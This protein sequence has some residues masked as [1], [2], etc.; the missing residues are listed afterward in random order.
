[1]RRIFK[2]EPQDKGKVIKNV[3]LKPDNQRLIEKYQRRVKQ[4]KSLGK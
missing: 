4:M 2:K 1:M 3:F